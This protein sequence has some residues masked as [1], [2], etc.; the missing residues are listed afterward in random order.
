MAMAEG[1]QRHAWDLQSAL[2]ALVASALGDTDARP[3]KFNPFECD[4]VQDEP[5]VISFTE[6]RAMFRS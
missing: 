4:D 1:R 2:M 6:A 3:E 5:E